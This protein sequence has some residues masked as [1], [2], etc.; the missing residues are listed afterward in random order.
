MSGYL[1]S[2]RGAGYMPSH[3]DLLRVLREK[4]PGEVKLHRDTYLDQHSR[5]IMLSASLIRSNHIA[6]EVWAALISRSRSEKDEKIIFITKYVEDY[7]SKPWD[8][9]REWPEDEKD[10]VVK[11]RL[12]QLFGNIPL[13]WMQTVI[14]KY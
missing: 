3:E 13:Q 11:K 5:C 2:L 9:K 14:E 12:L 10:L 7:E 6:T 4:F 8:I 1:R